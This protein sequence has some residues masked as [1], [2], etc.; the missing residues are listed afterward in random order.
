MACKA[1]GRKEGFNQHRGLAKYKLWVNH[2]LNKYG[3]GIIGLNGINE[4]LMGSIDREPNSI[5][6]RAAASSA[7]ENNGAMNNVYWAPLDRWAILKHSSTR[8]NSA[9]TAIYIISHRRWNGRQQGKE[10]A[11]CLYLYQAEPASLSAG[12]GK[13]VWTGFKPNDDHI[14]WRPYTS[15]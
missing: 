4:R 1:R 15:L 3:S 11:G 2:P 9:R 13:R 7:Q 12:P 14:E 8:V 10:L 6:I 5:I